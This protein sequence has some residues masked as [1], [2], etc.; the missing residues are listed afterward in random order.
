MSK[1]CKKGKIEKDFVK[2]VGDLCNMS[3]IGKIQQ[4]CLTDLK[5]AGLVI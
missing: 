4:D 1:I 2:K 5:K 3:K